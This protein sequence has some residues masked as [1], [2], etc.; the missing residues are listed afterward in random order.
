VAW[1]DFDITIETQYPRKRFKAQQAIPKDITPEDFVTPS[2]VFVGIAR[3]H[4]VSIPF[5]HRRRQM[6]A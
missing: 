2:V 5:W 1:I 3:L 4:S 6:D